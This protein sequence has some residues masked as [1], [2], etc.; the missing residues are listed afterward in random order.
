MKV[1][2]RLIVCL[3]ALLL[4]G[5]ASADELKIDYGGVS[6]NERFRLALDD[7]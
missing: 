4:A 5:S 7:G 3:V 2:V 6:V 1:T